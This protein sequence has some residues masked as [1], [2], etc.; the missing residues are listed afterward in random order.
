MA[1]QAGK[2]QYADGNEPNQHHRPEGPADLRRTERLRG[3][4]R[5]QDRDRQ[6]QNEI[7]QMRC[8]DLQAFERGENRDRRRNSTIAVDQRRAEQ[9]DGDDV[10]A[11]LAFDAE[12][13]HQRQYAAFTVVIDAHR[14]RDVFDRHDDDQRPDEQRQ[15]AEH[16]VLAGAAG[17][18]EDSLE[19]VERAR[20]DVAENDAE[21]GN[22]H[23][24]KAFAGLRVGTLVW[25]HDR[26]SG[27]SSGLSP[28]HVA[29]S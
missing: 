10:R 14:E 8:R 6:R 21:R 25:A 13:G 7:M 17:D 20:A 15:H 12:Q 22:A 29:F 11:M 16:N 26:G 3:K 4:Q 2:P 23:A 5:D 18:I 27:G 1:G 24:G 9:A 28:T 19:R